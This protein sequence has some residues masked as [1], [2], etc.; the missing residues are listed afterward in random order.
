VTRVL[1]FLAGVISGGLLDPV[2]W[3]FLILPLLICGFYRFAGW[4]LVPVASL[5]FAS[6]QTALVWWV[7]QVF[8]AAGRAQRFAW[9]FV[10]LTLIAALAY[11][12]GR[13]TARLVSR[14]A[15]S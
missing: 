9:I 11:G 6:I 10:G 4:W 2:V 7:W 3:V 5:I 15:A 12:V 14:R 8:D 1:H 13:L